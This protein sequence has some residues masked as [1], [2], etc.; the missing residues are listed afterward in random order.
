M[1]L[2]ST[3]NRSLCFRTE[4][5]TAYHTIPYHT[6]RHDTTRHATTR[7]ATIPYHTIPHD[8][9]R[10][11]T[12]RHDTIP[13]HTTRHDTTRHH[14]IS[15]HII[16]YHTVPYHTIPYPESCP[17]ASTLSLPRSN[18]AQVVTTNYCCCSTMKKNC[19]AENI[20]EKIVDTDRVRDKGTNSKGVY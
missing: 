15:Y 2:T 8:T 14:T 4:W 16:P 6:I 19:R 13:Y 12:Q 17:V 10:H 7:H 20:F 9:T 18:Y 5:F 1:V 3:P 11:D